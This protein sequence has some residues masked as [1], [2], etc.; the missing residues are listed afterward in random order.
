MTPRQRRL[1]NEYAGLQRLAAARPEISVQVTREEM[2]VPVRYLV[3]YHLRSLCGVTN[4]E[5]LGEDGYE[6]EPLYAD[7]FRLS[8]SFPPSYPAI[9]AMPVLEFE[10]CDEEHRP[11]PHPWHPNIRYFG[12]FSGAVCMNY[13]DSYDSVAWAVDRVLSYLRY[14]LYHAENEPPYPEDL[15]VARWVLQNE[16][17][18]KTD[19]NRDE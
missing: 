14:E 7:E 2:G 17:K 1:S 11:I 15:K 19:N 6:N 18:I 8:V 4:V 10:V 3:L 9:D 13:T 16:D 12:A 5:H